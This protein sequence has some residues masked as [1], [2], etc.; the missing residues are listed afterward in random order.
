MPTF[1]SVVPNFAAE[2]GAALAAEGRSALVPQLASAIIDRCTYDETV[3]A[4]Y[5]YFVRPPPSPHFTN[6]AAPVAETIPFL[7]DGFNIDVDHDGNIFGIEFLSRPDV[8]NNLR[9]ANAL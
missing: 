9:K 3:E 5:V 4:G 6:L 8:I 2:V 1:E 7:P